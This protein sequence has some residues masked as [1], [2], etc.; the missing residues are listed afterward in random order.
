[1]A[2]PMRRWGPRPARKK[3]EGAWYG[4][5]VSNLPIASGTPTAY[6]LWDDVATGIVGAPGKLVHERTHLTLCVQ[7]NSLVAA[8]Q[9]AWYVSTFTTDAS[10]NVP[11]AGLYSPS[12]ASENVAMK[13]LMTR[14]FRWLSPGAGTNYTPY[15]GICI[16]LDLKTRRKLDDT[17]AIMFCFESSASLNLAFMWRTYCSW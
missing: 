11:S 17:D 6:Y 7:A 8:T 13:P 3:R 9:L 16:E 12:S 10:N 5:F 2:L 4:G 1:M 15:E 14:S